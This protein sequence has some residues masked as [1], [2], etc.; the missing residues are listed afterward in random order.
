MFCSKCGKEINDDALFC[1]FCGAKITNEA[2]PQRQPKSVL[3]KKERYEQKFT[4]PQ[5]E[6]D[7]KALQGKKKMIVGFFV[8]SIILTVV[9]LGIAILFTVLTALYPIR[10]SY[11]AFSYTYPNPLYVGLCSTF[12]SLFTLFLVASIALPILNRTLIGK[13]IAK[14]N[15]VIAILKSE[16]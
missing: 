8:T 9:C 5:L 6:E 1:Q 15:A 4:I 14:R 16:D 2:K 12:Y 10:A 11:D 3:T 13:K 7:I